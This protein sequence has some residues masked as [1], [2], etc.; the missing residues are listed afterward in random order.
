M[1]T[2]SNI[3]YIATG[4]TCCRVQKSTKENREGDHPIIHDIKGTWHV[5]ANKA[6]VED[7]WLH[8]LN[9]KQTPKDTGENKQVKL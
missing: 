4:S 1:R 5:S 2:Y 6:K 3:F 7:I 9:T 8:S